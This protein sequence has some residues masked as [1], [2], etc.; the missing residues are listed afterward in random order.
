MLSIKH[1]LSL[2][3]LETLTQL[4]ALRYYLSL[5]NASLML[6]EHIPGKL[7]L[8]YHA[9]SDLAREQGNVMKFLELQC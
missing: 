3:S 4:G 9:D 7:Q 1:C 5:G 2:F 8:Q 6:C